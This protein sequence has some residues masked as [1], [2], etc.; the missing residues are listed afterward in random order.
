MSRSLVWI[1]LALIAIV[2]FVACEDWIA[3]V[4]RVTEAVMTRDRPREA[5]FEP[6]GRNGD[7]GS[8]PPTRPGAMFYGPA[9]AGEA[10]LPTVIDHEPFQKIE[11]G[12]E[13]KSLLGVDRTAHPTA[14]GKGEG[15]VTIGS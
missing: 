9:V 6:S 5:G 2:V 7:G 8:R 4:P 10:S 15:T 3:P 12:W 14:S 1:D 13:T 11:G